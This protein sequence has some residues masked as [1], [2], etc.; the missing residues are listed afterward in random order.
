MAAPEGYVERMSFNERVQ[1]G[2]MFVTFTLLAITGFLVFLPEKY[3]DFLG[4]Q[5]E[6]FFEWRG[7]IHR[8]S[9]VLMVAISIYHAGYLAFSER[10]RWHFRELLPKMKDV[11]DF[12]QMMRH[13]LQKEQPPP[14]FGWYS[15]IEKAEYWA[16][17]W[18]TAVMAATGFML[19]FESL[20][21][22]IVLDVAVIVHQYEAI[23]AVLAIF[24]WHFY[25]V[26]WKPE[27]FP[28]S[29]IWLTGQMSIEELRHHH[30]LAYQQMIASENAECGIRNAE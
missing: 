29:P 20:F 19:W 16:L 11:T 2:V 8:V 27:V 18:G 14:Q 28:M 24:V 15:Y 22:K 6:P 26:H 7:H 10:G 25:H 4:D 13:F 30:P 21:P 3:V 12:L 17:V 9:G 5:R 1:H 23:L